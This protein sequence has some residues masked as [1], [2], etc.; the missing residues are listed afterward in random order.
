[1]YTFITLAII[2]MNC[3]HCGSHLLETY[4]LCFYFQ[5]E[6]SVSLI[7][8]QEQYVTQ[9]KNFKLIADSRR[10]SICCPKCHDV[11][12]KSVPCGPNNTTYMAFGNEK[13]Y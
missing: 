10:T 4:S 7:V 1:M 12:G 13:V 9:L 5:N 2:R 6:D 8:K 3:R 11:V